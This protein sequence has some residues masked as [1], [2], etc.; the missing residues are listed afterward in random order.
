MTDPTGATSVNIVFDADP[1]QNDAAEPTGGLEATC[2]GTAV[3]MD[4][5]DT[6]TNCANA[7][8]D[9]HAMEQVAAAP[10]DAGG[11][12]MDTLWILTVA[13]SRDTE[14]FAVVHTAPAIPLKS[15]CVMFVA[16][17]LV[18]VKRYV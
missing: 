7:F 17:A 6:S 3:D 18:E 8:A 9:V 12:Q 5:S 15:S 4:V 10:C 13:E 16:V 11:A 14:L 1:S 2:A